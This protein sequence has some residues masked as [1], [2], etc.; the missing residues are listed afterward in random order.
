MSEDPNDHRK[1][2]LQVS[3]ISETLHNID[4]SSRSSSSD[5]GVPLPATEPDLGKAVGTT[6]ANMSYGFWPNASGFEH[7]Q[8]D[9]YSSIPV[10]HA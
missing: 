10:S 2:D 8:R 6:E 3:Q 1:P 7:Y 5:A 4:I 9:E